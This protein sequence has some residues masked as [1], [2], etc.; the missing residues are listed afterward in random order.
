MRRISEEFD[1]DT[2]DIEHND[3]Q[4]SSQ[5]ASNDEPQQRPQYDGS[6]LGDASFVEEDDDSEFLLDEALGRDGL[7]WRMSSI[8]SL[9]ILSKL[10]WTRQL[11]KSD[12]FVQIGT[13][14]Y[15]TF[16]HLSGP[17]S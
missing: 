2:I 9:T 14:D 8:L 12:A 15:I 7:Y 5:A 11:Q 1:W 3:F 17:A 16:L 4:Q 13:V 10:I 6:G